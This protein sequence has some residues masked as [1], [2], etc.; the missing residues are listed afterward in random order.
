MSAHTPGPWTAHGAIVKSHTG[1]VSESP[2]WSVLGPAGQR[3]YV[4]VGYE[5]INPQ[6]ERDARLIAAAPDLL[7]A[8]QLCADFVGSPSAYS[9]TSDDGMYALAETIEAVLAKATGEAQ[10]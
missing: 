2:N 6:A 7:E 1:A 3:L 5:H 10:P 8:L 9:P 4:T